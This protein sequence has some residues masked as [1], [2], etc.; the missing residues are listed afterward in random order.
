MIIRETTHRF[1][2]LSF[3]RA[4]VGRRLPMLLTAAG[5]AYF[6]NCPAGEQEEIVEMLQAGAGGV[7]QQIIARDGALVRALIKRV[8]DA[9]YGGN[10]GDW[11]DQAKIGALAVP[12]FAD[13]AVRGSLSVV[14]LR[15]A[16]ALAEAE[17]KFLPQLRQAA[18][19]IGAALE[20]DAG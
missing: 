5:R 17:R 12:V 14:Y 13:G 4:M 3:N 1:S 15:R 18:L 6:A 8:R 19:D 11:A 16:V 9:G 7:E 20:S 2:P 10:N